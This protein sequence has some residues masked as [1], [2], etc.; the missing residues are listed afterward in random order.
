MNTH[1]GLYRYLR[2]PSE[3][4]SAS[5]IFQRA[6]DTILQGISH[7][8][9]YLDDIL[10]IGANDQE[11]LRNMEEVIKR[12]QYHGIHLKLSKYSFLQE[13]IEYLG[14]HIEAEGLHTTS[15]KVEAVQLAPS[16]K[17]QA[18]L[19]SFLGLVLYYGIFWPE[20]SS[21]IHV[22]NT[23]LQTNQKWK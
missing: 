2:L 19:R 9:C 11:Y 20:L 6:M 13:S 22:F 1:K 10:I 4:A 7:V 14:H 12:L 16:P 23:L 15:R 21:V 3:V 17:D 5:A 18:Q 8:V